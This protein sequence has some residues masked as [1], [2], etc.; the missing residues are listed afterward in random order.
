[1]FDST[2][3][4]LDALPI[5]ACVCGATRELIIREF[6]LEFRRLVDNDNNAGRSL[7][8]FFPEVNESPLTEFDNWLN[9]V[10]KI[11]V[12]EVAKYENQ[13]L[14]HTR[15]VKCA[16]VDIY[17]QKLAP[18][19]SS[20]SPSKLLCILIDTTD[21]ARKQLLIDA[22]EQVF[23]TDGI[24]LGVHTV[25]R[26]KGTDENNERFP[27]GFMNEFEKEL[28]EIRDFSPEITSKAGP[29]PNSDDVLDE[30]CKPSA[31]FLDVEYLS[32]TN[33]TSY[34]SLSGKLSA[35]FVNE[36]MANKAG[37]RRH[38]FFYIPPTTVL[39]QRS[40][41]KALPVN[42]EDIWIANPNSLT[43]AECILTVVRDE[44]IEESVK[45]DLIRMGPRNPIL[46][47]ERIKTFIKVQFCHLNPQ[48]RAWLQKRREVKLLQPLADENFIFIYGNQAFLK[49]LREQGRLEPS[50]RLLGK[51]EAD[52]Y[53][54]TTI[55]V[56]YND[57]DKQVMQQGTEDERIE[58]HPLGPYRGEGDHDA[59]TLVQVL[60]T[61]YAQPSAS[62]RKW[63]NSESG[64]Y[65]VVGFYW[66]ATTEKI[67]ERLR[68]RFLPLTLLESSPL[69]SFR[70]N[71]AN[72]F[73]YVNQAFIDDNGRD[74]W[75]VLGA[76]DS[77]FFRDHGEKY[78]ADDDR[79]IAEWEAAIRADHNAAKNP[80]ELA[81]E[82]FEEHPTRDRSGVKRVRVW[83]WPIV[84]AEG[85]I[86]GI[87]GVY[88][89]AP[90]P[91]QEASPQK[92]SVDLQ[93][94]KFSVDG[95]VWSFGE[96][97]ERVPKADRH[98]SWRVLCVLA[99]SFD[100]PVNDVE[101]LRELGE[102]KIADEV[103]QGGG[104][105]NTLETWISGARAVLEHNRDLFQLDIPKKEAKGAAYR[106]KSFDG[107]TS[108]S[109]ERPRKSR[110]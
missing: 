24:G 28:L 49:E 26:T 15:S 79:L 80:R 60:K 86:I 84:S 95:T 2:R 74:I 100:Q 89:D 66:E 42:I 91:I 50:E 14:K 83:K 18:A 37:S 90:Q 45:R 16:R 109:Q 105:S 38:R 51:T 29:D 58:E 11:S 36:S 78:M 23:N 35:R 44:R 81:R 101:L 20:D 25:V 13:T 4:F 31:R 102:E 99:K 5:P 63:L 110:K 54:E 12:G 70:K 96:L 67:G 6:N 8:D 21:A 69:R 19:G 56:T 82:F 85:A 1:M 97:E 103:R 59:T 94:K 77:K 34:K 68:A 98:D 43:E 41:A 57:A 22:Y 40:H 72:E 32:A 64:P 30:D 92:V 10:A 3:S 48:A 106:L 107:A 93:R 9:E 46:V 76:T 65:G 17:I 73:T 75:D 87:E 104:S 55:H 53:P 108:E 33:Q 62:V 61:P 88:C 39:S 27:I 47:D 7:I 71:R 52:L